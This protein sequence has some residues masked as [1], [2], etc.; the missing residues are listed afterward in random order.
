ME[1][2]IHACPQ[3]MWYVDGFLVPALA[4]Q[5]ADRV[6]IWNDTDAHGCLTACM[7]AFASCAGDGGTWHIQDDVLLSRDFVRAARE[8][9]EGVVYGFC[10]EYFLDDPDLTG[11]VYVPDAWH[12][13]QCVRIPDSY[14]RE[15]AEWY[16]SGAWRQESPEPE[17]YALEAKNEGDDGFFREFL[18][19]RHGTETV[20]NMRPNM[21]EH[22]DLLLGGSVLHAYG[23]YRATAHYWNDK[24]LVAQLRTELKARQLGSWAI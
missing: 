18:Q 7:E 24:D 8:H 23:E 14:A 15:C 9:D 4:A 1:V 22:V 20:R 19:C 17:L 13:F 2:M 16:F 12:S 10:C 3:R 21:V 5:G 6:R 11:T